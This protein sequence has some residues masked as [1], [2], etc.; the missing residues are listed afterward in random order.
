VYSVPGATHLS[1]NE[2]GCEAREASLISTDTTCPLRDHLAGPSQSSTELWPAA[3]TNVSQLE[4][5][6]DPQTGLM[7]TATYL[8]PSITGLDF[9]DPAWLAGPMDDFQTICASISQAHVVPYLLESSTAQCTSHVDSDPSR[10]ESRVVERNLA[11]AIGR[12]WYS[13]FVQFSRT[14]THDESFS[15]ESRV[16]DEYRERLSQGL[17][18]GPSGMSLP[19]ADFL[20]REQPYK[21]QGLLLISFRISVRGCISRDSTQYS[22]WC[23][24][25]LFDLHLE[26]HFYFYPFVP[27]GL[28]S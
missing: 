2:N 26:I 1:S 11:T 27:S 4:N 21:F 9:Q 10:S 20:V 28:C 17:R 18:A 24:H 14:H 6:V 5:T 19:S 13:R 16:D 22:L 3:P 8:D 23:M 7:S 15:R 12:N 25:H